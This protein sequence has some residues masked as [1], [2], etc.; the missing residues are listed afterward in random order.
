MAF[1][2]LD[3]W[4]PTNVGSHSTDH[5]KKESGVCEGGIAYEYKQSKQKINIKVSGK[6]EEATLGSITSRCF[7]HADPRERRKSSLERPLQHSTLQL[8][9]G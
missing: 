2:G 6:I 5:G 4:N 3:L 8:N 9:C 1:F 7:G